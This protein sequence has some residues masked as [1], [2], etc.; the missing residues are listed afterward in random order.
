[1]IEEQISIPLKNSNEALKLLGIGDKN[2]K[3]L[4]RKF[5][6]RLSIEDNELLIKGNT[7]NTEIIKVRLKE[8]IAKLRNDMDMHSNVVETILMGDN[9]NI[10]SFEVNS[11]RID[12]KSIG[13]SNLIDK[14]L[15]DPLVLVTGPAGTGKTFLTVACACRL[16]EEGKIERI[17]L[18]RPVVEAGESLGF[19]PGDIDSKVFPYFRPLHDSLVKLLGFPATKRM[20]D[21]GVIEMAPLAYMRGRTLEDAFLILDE[22]QNTTIA[23]MKMFL[24]RMGKGSKTVVTGDP[25]QC[26]LPKNKVSGLTHSLNILSKIENVGVVELKGSDMV[27]HPLVGKIDKAF[28]A[29]C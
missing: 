8:V 10:S 29:E 20:F 12:P 19:L 18:C 25:S 6:V 16:L 21:S 22:A 17:I 9:K 15:K 23:Q 5:G 1:M 7:V 24:T 14:I 26:D 11:E 4:K 2:A 13:Q 28:G 27:R 3:N